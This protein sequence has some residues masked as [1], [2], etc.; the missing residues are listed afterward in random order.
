MKLKNMKEYTLT[1]KELLK[2]LN[3]KGEF[4]VMCHDSDKVCI[5]VEVKQ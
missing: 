5:V 2:K 4:F 1:T 3:I